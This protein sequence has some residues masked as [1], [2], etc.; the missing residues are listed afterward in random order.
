M[1]ALAVSDTSEVNLSRHRGRLKAADL[2][3]LSNDREVGF[4]LHPTLVLDVQHQGGFPLGVS[5]EG[6]TAD[7]VFSAPQQ[8]C[9]DA[10]SIRLNGRT[11]KQQNPFPPKTLA[12]A[13]WL[14]ARLGGWSGYASQHS[15]GI[16]TLLNGLK[17]FETLFEGWSLSHG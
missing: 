13:S 11:R 7:V 5:D 8:R 16:V 1:H 17:P 6:R 15:P 4:F 9:L 12:W 3:S 14:I 2:G 10:L